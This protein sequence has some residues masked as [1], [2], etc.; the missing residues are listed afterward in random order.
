MIW[1]QIIKDKINKQAIHLSANDY[2]E[3]A[4]MLYDYAANVELGDSTN[5][6]GHAA[7]VY[8]NT[9]F[10]LDFSRTQENAINAALDYGYGIILSVFNREIVSNGY[11]TQLGLRHKNQFNQFNLSSDLMEPFR[12]L[13]DRIVVAQMPEKFNKEM[14][15]ELIGILSD[16]V[17]IDGKTMVT[18]DA[19]KVYCKSVFAALS[20][21]D[22]FLIKFYNYEL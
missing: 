12:I 14:K 17:I 1:T 2:F 21:E 5:R 3:R 20:K 11:I 18:M 7:K 6:E 4:C 19:I 8:F 13:V 9:L 16:P 15:Y 22:P 10:G